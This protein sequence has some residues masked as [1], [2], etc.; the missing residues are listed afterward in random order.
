MPRANVRDALRLR[1]VAVQIL[2]GSSGRPAFPSCSDRTWNVFLR[3]ERCAM[4]LKARLVAAG[5][6]VPDQ[7]EHAATREL[8]RVLSARGQLQRI[9]RL[10]LADGIPAVVLKGGVAALA[11]PAPVDL[12][13]VDVLVRALQAERLATLLD[14]EGFSGTGPAG[15]AHLAQRVAPN[16]VQIEVHFALNDFE[17]DETIWGRI[18]PLDGVPGLWRLCAA[19]HLW[20]L[21]VH[22][23]VT[24]P[25]RRGALRDVLLITE[26]IGD[27]DAAALGTVERRVSAHP[28][29]QQLGDL[30]A[31]A[32]E[33]RDGLPVEDRFR[34]EAAAN[35][36]LRGPL[37]LRYSRFWMT[38]FLTALF[39]QLGGATD[40]RLEWAT[41]WQRP[42]FPSPWGLAARLEHRWPALGRWCRTAT[43]VAR[44][45]A[46]RAAAWPVAAVVRYVS[47]R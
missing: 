30:L 34:R 8:Q 23:V 10:V 13:D 20:H 12:T 5:W 31:M 18:R 33:L 41:A 21:L 35:Y 1:A 47:S 39:A 7:I 16:A 24:H 43:R 11:S 44:L 15:T 6:P 36:V 46:A 3:T 22:T 38:A 2:S 32:R 25:Y 19:D 29:S 4:A 14:G 28:L 42:P 27:C 26:A 37:G 40:R 17:F 45:V 9:A